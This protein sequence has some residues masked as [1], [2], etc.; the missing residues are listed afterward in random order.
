[1]KLIVTCIAR[2]FLTAGFQSFRLLCKKQVERL[3][4]G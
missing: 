3:E 1:M 4:S 2:L